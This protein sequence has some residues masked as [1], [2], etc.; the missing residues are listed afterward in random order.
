L[1]T[2]QGKGTYVTLMFLSLSFSLSL[3]K[4]QLVF[5]KSSPLSWRYLPTRT[6]SAKNSLVRDFFSPPF[7]HQPDPRKED[8]HASLPPPPQPSKWKQKVIYYIHTRRRNTRRRMDALFKF[9]TQ[10]HKGR[11]RDIWVGQKSRYEFS[12]FKYT[13]PPLVTFCL[14]LLYPRVKLNH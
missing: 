7:A 2:P 5:K 6:Q 11:W 4:V 10:G 9:I 13:K 3:L 12:R 14:S 8:L 1:N